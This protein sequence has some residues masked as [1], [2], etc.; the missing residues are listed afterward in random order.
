MPFAARCVDYG[1]LIVASL[2]G[3]GALALFVVF[4]FAG[5]PNLV[6]LG[7]GEAQVLWLDAGLC[8]AFF[9]QHS[10]MI[11]RAFRQRLARVLSARYDGAVYAIVSGVVLLAVIVL[12]QESASTVAVPGTSVRWL[13]RAFYFL[14]LAGFVWGI[15][16]LGFFD[17]C[18]VTPILAHLR[19]TELPPAPLVVRGPYRWVRHPLY[20]CLLVMMWSHPD[21]T[22]DRVLFNVLWTAW[23]IAG[24]ALEER[25]LVVAYGEAY[26]SYQR[27][28]PMLLPWR[29][30]SS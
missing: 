1:I 11:R 17:P 20:L 13:L 30:F 26:R 8:L 28:V 2:V 21:L 9:V 6:H 7:L 5:S 19:N 14:S 4:L 22:T 24:T 25:D 16:A 3:G 29:I 23:M 15:W 18:G 10:G 12:W 27:S